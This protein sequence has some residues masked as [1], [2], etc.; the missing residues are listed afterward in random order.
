M[1]LSGRSVVGQ[2]KWDV[3]PERP[4]EDRTNSSHGDGKEGEANNDDYQEGPH[5]GSLP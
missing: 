4:A 1:V 3:G 5:S 2:G